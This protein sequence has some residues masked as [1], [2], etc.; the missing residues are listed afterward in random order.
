[1]TAGGVARRSKHGPARAAA[2]LA[3]SIALML[4]AILV[5]AILAIS[6][7]Q[8]RLVFL[9]PPP[10]VTQGL[11]A[12]RLEFSSS[13]EQPLFAFLVDPAA[14]DSGAR[15]RFIFV[16]HGN[17]DLADSWIDWGRDVANRTGWSVFMPEY[18]GYGG[19]PGY[20]TGEGV[21]QDARAALHLLGSRYGAKPEEIVFYAHSIG[22]G[23]AAQLADEAGARALILEA[24]M[25]SIL[26]V[27]QQ[28]FGAPLSGFL[29]L[30]S[31]IDL[32]PIVHVPR[33]R[34]PVWVAFGDRDEVVPP[35]MA[36]AVYAAAPRKGG[37]LV[38]A[39]AGHN[40]VGPRGGNSYRAW[41]DA[42]LL[43]A[44]QP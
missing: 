20:P 38:V 26:A 40:D 42:A 13:P 44:K 10:P 31:R 43:Q 27:G 17:G 29:P 30:V 7:F 32:A 8:E 11:G 12:T 2:D 36:R 16:L 39:G 21:L 5:V 24:P 35:S 14:S 9:P 15:R 37:L 41:L 25:T 28:S 6:I 19:L 18:R 33:V 1:V 3:L 4:G 34:A 22:T 23:I